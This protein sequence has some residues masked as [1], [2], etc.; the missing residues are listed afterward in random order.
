MAFWK[1]KRV[2]VTGG[3]G[4]LGRHV[5]NRL[6]RAGANVFVPRKREYDLITPDG[7]RRCLADHPAD[8][9]L[10]GAAFYGGLGIN[11]A[12]P[13]RIFY[14]NI[15]MGVNLMEAARGAG[16]SKFVTIGT[17]CSYPGYSEG[18]LREADFWAGPLHDSVAHYGLTKKILQ[19]QGQAYHRQFG[20]RSIHLVLTNLYGPWDSYNPQR[21]HVVA[22]LIR[23]W[24]E[25]TLSAAPT[26]E[27]W[28][29]GRPVRE[30]LYV[31]DAAE[32]VLLAAEKYDDVDL[33]LNV[34]T[35]E[36]TSIRRL[37][38]LIHEASGYQGEIVWRTDKPDGAMYKVLDVSRMVEI[39]GWQPPTRLADGLARTIAWYA[40]HKPEADARF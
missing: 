14:E 11:Q 22:A 15:S 18:K 6:E 28:G 5:V 10:H 40:Q 16:V 34:G 1:G 9:V 25:A 2:T 38:E 24:V 27:V 19:V 8:M 21:S 4:F 36:G 30:F 23:K 3:A 35:G 26:I 20:F 33:P 29:T 13:G 12:Q 31:D 39:L 7:C 17:A 32:A 37:V